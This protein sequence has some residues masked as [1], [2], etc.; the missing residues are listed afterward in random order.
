MG[1]QKGSQVAIDSEVAQEL[2]RMINKSDLTQFELANAIGVSNSNVLTMFKQ[3][4][5]KIPIKYV[6][7]L[8]EACGQDPKILMEI[9]LKE[10][11]PDILESLGLVY[12]KPTTEEEREVLGVFRRALANKEKRR[13]AAIRAKNPNEGEERRK[14][15]FSRCRIDTSDEAK[16]ELYD[17][18][19]K[20]SIV[21]N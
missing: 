9:A 8:S 18:V 14:A 4:R 15:T 20:N 17:F 7:S 12:E 1:R 19:Y 11:H 16:K 3:G 2:T 21:S 10:Y 6:K 5:T 13:K